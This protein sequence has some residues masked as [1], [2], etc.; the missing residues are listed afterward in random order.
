MD[1]TYCS[2]I[3]SFLCLHLSSQEVRNAQKTWWAGKV[4]WT[5]TKS[6]GTVVFAS[7]RQSL[8]R[9]S[10]L[11]T[12]FRENG[13][14]Y[15]G[16]HWLTERVACVSSSHAKRD[17][18]N[19]RFNYG[20]SHKLSEN[21][22]WSVSYNKKNLRMLAQISLQCVR[23]AQTKIPTLWR[24]TRTLYCATQTEDYAGTL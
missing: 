10:G 22:Q 4:P 2:L 5:I 17:A 12:C 7:L 13:R 3:S 1:P 19:G 20:T 16:P 8:L 6:R 23:S 11:H 24:C 15:L 18:L 14:A 9:Q 21:S